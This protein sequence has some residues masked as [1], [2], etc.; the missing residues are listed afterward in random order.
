MGKYVVYTGPTTA[1]LLSND[2][3]GK[4]T[5][6]VYQT[7]TA[8]VH[9]GGAKLVRGYVEQSKTK[10]KEPVEPKPTNEAFKGSVSRETVELDADKAEEKEMEEDYDDSEKEDPTR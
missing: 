10:E 5:S 2:V 4:L 6:S 9:L 7:L 3:Y 8:G 1:W